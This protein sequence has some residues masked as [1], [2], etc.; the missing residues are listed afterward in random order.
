[1]GKAL[2]AGGMMGSHANI[3]FHRTPMRGGT[4]KSLATTILA[5]LTLWVGRHSERKQMRRDLPKLTYEMLKDLH[6]THKQAQKLA[7]R[8]F[9][10]A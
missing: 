7:N 1:M 2:S 5:K 9:W 8:P 6:L 4:P 10:R 3:G